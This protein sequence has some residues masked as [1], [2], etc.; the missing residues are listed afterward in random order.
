M[1]KRPFADK[2]PIGPLM[3]I[4]LSRERGEKIQLGTSGTSMPD[5]PKGTLNVL[6]VMDRHV[7]TLPGDVRS[8]T[9]RDKIWDKVDGKPYLSVK[10]SGRSSAAPFD[11]QAVIVRLDEDNLPVQ[12]GQINRIANTIENHY[13]NLDFDVGVKNIIFDTE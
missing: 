11:E 2:R 5:R 6:F 13:S 4:D 3:D 7:A 10:R 12:Q 1:S 9:L 8:G